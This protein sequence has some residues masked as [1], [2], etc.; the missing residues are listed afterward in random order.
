VNGSL[1]GQLRAA[2]NAARKERDQERT[3]LLSTI[4]SDVRNREI[5]L[6][7]PLDDADVV[8]VLRRGIRHRHEAVEAFRAGGRTEA[9][10]REAREVKALE[11]YLPAAPSDDEIRGA[12]REAIGAG[13]KDLG[14]LMGKVMPLFK[15]RADGKTVNRIA[16]EELAAAS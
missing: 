13:A 11:A 3:L 15:G 2:L 16:R 4:L 5:E 10:D 14:A 6:A 7:R 9:A 1:A 12:V 8:E